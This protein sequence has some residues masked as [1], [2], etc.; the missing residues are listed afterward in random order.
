[1]AE[2]KTAQLVGEATIA[3]ARREGVQRTSIDVVEVEMVGGDVGF[4]C[5][6]RGVPFKCERRCLQVAP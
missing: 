4:A 6:Q 1:M 2:C 3:V 5:C